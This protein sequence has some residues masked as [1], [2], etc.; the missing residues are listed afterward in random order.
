MFETLT[1]RLNLV[2]D[3]IRRRGKLSEEDVDAALRDVRLAL[4]EADIHFGVV[5]T[6]IARARAV[7]SEVSK[8]LNPAQQ[9]IK[10]V[11]DE[12]ITTLGE[13]IPLSLSGPRP[14]LVMLVGLQGSG[15]TTTAGKLARLLQSS[16]ERVMLVAADPHR[17][18]ATEQL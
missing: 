8:A 18:A 11:N 1:S 5:K 2:F 17:P 14:R 15:K 16:G 3:Q 12:L 4:L 9:V 6:L 10:I 13:A 7:G